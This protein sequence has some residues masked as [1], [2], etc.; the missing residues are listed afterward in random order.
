MPQ[1]Y[2]EA[3]D[4]L[5]QQ[6]DRSAG[7]P[8]LLARVRREPFSPSAKSLELLCVKP[9]RSRHWLGQF[10]PW[11]ELQRTQVAL[12]VLG[13]HRRG[14]LVETAQRAHERPFADGNLHWAARRVSHLRPSE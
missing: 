4:L 6:E 14:L 3:V 5:H 2:I 10:R 1:V 13:P 11:H 12:S 9:V 8:H 7:C